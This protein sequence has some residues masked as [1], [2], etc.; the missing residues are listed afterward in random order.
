MIELIMRKFR[1]S[2]SQF[3]GDA[4]TEHFTKPS[5]TVPNEALSVRELLRRHNAGTL[6][7]DIVIP[8]EFTGDLDDV[9]GLDIVQLEEKTKAHAKVVDDLKDQL[10]EQRTKKQKTATPEEAFG[11][12]GQ[13]TLE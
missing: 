8:S 11:D 5:L 4:D 6:T 12:K 3:G 1:V 10:S 9:R 13:G 7:E 2:S